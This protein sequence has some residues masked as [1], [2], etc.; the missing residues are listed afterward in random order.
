MAKFQKF[1]RLNRKK[2]LHCDTYY[3]FQEIWIRNQKSTEYREK[4]FYKF[5]P[6]ESPLAQIARINNGILN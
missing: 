3:K 6:N 5:N 1:K 4:S 2:M